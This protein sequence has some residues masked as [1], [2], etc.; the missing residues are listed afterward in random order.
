MHDLAPLT[1]T[2]LQ[3]ADDCFMQELC[4]P[5]HEFINQDLGGGSDLVYELLLWL[6]FAKL[7]ILFQ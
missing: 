3:P 5:S 4:S 1:K 2:W 7:Q 6:F